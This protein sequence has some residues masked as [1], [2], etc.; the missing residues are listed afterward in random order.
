MYIL[1]MDIYVS[2]QIFETYTGL[3]CMSL[4]LYYISIINIILTTF[5]WSVWG[6]I[7]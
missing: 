3:C 6:K 5:S 1:I 7:A 4:L 2:I